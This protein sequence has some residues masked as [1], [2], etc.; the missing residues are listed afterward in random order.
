MIKADFTP[1]NHSKIH[2]HNNRIKTRMDKRIKT[3]TDKA[4]KTP[5][6]H[7]EVRSNTN[8]THTNGH[9]IRGNIEVIR[10]INV[11]LII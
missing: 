10:W 1:N 9:N 5:I 2:T 3:P 8:N 6:K 11:V 7:T 4:I